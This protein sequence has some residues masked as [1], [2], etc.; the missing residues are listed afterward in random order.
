MILS[1]QN[2]LFNVRSILN[3]VNHR[4]E[5]FTFSEVVTDQAQYSTVITDNIVSMYIFIYSSFHNTHFSQIY[6]I[7]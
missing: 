4:K 5:I 3:N 1:C 7:W 2:K 6:Q